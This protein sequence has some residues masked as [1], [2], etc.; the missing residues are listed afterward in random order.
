[1]R[2]FRE[3]L[4]RGLVSMV[5]QPL[6]PREPAAHAWTRARPTSRSASWTRPSACSAQD[7]PGGEAARR[8]P[9]RRQHR[10]GRSRSAVE[11]EALAETSRSWPS[12]TSR[13][14]IARR[15]APPF[16][17]AAVREGRGAAGPR[18]RSTSCDI[19][20][21]PF[22]HRPLVEA[23]AARGIHVLCEKPIAAMPPRTRR[24]SRVRC[25]RRV[26][27][28]A[29]CHQYH[30]SPQWQAVRAAAAAHRARPPRRVRGAAHGG[31][32]RATPNWSPAWRTDREPGRRRHPVRPR[33]AHL[34][35]AALGAR[36]ARRA[37][38]DRAHAAATPTTASRTRPSSML[39]F[40]DHLAEVRL[41][42]AA[43]RRAIRFLFVGRDGELV[44]DDERVV[45]RAADDRGG[46]VRGADEP[47]LVALRLVRA[48]DPRLRRPRARWR[49][50]RRPPSTRPSSWCG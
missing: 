13:R 45:V 19:C 39:D 47:G 42:W 8:A 1:M 50:L 2:L 28:F 9:G 26:I 34:L 31:E 17:R 23:A 3:C 10:A 38:G 11:R 30:H 20:T 21:P 16:R 43:R 12:P 15:R 49:P 22:T 24:R 14:P 46:L 7:G 5:L 32:L 37:A 18:A 44:G 40:G 27:V 33:R 48:A 6:L 25:A 35:P 41:T 4:R 29:P 36:R